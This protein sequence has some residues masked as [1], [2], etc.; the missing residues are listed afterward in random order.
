MLTMGQW[1]Y[2]ET[3]VMMPRRE[4]W[5]ADTDQELFSW[6]LKPSEQIRVCEGDSGP[7]IVNSFV[8]KVE[9]NLPIK[10][11]KIAP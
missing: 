11:A 7:E 10:L 9:E 1:N 6:Y 3:T 4:V 2:Q 8:D 5:D